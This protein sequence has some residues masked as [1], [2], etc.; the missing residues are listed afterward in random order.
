M[1]SYWNICY[2]KINILFN[3]DQRRWLVWIAT[4][5]Y[6]PHKLGHK[7]FLYRVYVTRCDSVSVY[8]V[9]KVFGA[10]VSGISCVLS[11]SYLNIT[12]DANGKRSVFIV[13]ATSQ[14]MIG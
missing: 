7:L 9:C 5:L 4:D 14:R 6:L 11:T 2:G 8:Y 10:Q 3:M 13:H 1:L 12:C